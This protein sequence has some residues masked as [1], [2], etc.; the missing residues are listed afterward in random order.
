[1]KVVRFAEEEHG[2]EDYDD[3][4]YHHCVGKMK[5]HLDPELDLC[6]E[7]FN[8]FSTLIQHLREAHDMILEENVDY[9]MACNIL[10]DSPLLGVYH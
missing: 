9:C 6:M 4:E 1:M 5:S 3:E 2:D 8:N 10:F 7:K